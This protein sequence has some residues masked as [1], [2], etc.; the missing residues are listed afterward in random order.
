MIGLSTLMT[1]APVSAKN[2]V[3]SGPGR[4]V[5]KSNTVMVGDTI[6]DALMAKNCE[7]K[8]I[9][10]EWGFNEKS[11]LIQNGAIDIARNFIDLY[12]IIIK[13]F[14]SIKSQIWAI[15]ADFLSRSISISDLSIPK[16][17][18]EITESSDRYICCGT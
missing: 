17:I 10:V 8:F 3:A 15:L 9:G 7:I 16:A 4:R 5:E 11:L 18:F 13:H 12:E 2:N 1:S 14:D 6:N